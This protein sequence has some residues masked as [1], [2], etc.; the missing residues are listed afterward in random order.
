ML[1]SYYG[2]YIVHGDMFLGKI[3]EPKTWDHATIGGKCIKTSAV[4]AIHMSNRKTENDE[5]NFPDRQPSLP[6]SSGIA[7]SLVYF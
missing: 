1:S 2:W 3:R 4:R 5:I 7:I 6:R